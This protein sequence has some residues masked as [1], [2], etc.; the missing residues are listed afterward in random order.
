MASIVA[1]AQPKSD[2]IPPKN[3]PKQSVKTNKGRA[4]PGAKAH[5]DGG[6][7]DP[8]KAPETTIPKDDWGKGPKGAKTAPKEPPDS[9]TNKAINKT[10]KP[11]AKT[12][13]KE[14]AAAKK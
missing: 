2:K 10:D 4:D 6:G 7:T 14:N 12:A 9:G 3:Q 13:A 11:P 8:M 5:A 1:V